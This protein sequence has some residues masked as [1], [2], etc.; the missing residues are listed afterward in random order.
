MI[1]L[2]NTID[3]SRTGVLNHLEFADHV[4]WD[5]SKQTIVLIQ[6][7]DYICLDYSLKLVF[8]EILFDLAYLV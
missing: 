1:I 3:K 8:G 5:A 6:A 2:P 4:V 7:T